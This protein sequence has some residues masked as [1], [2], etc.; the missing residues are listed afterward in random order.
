MKLIQFR[1]H[2]LQR[3]HKFRKIFRIEHDRRL[4]SSTGLLGNLEELAVAALL[5][6]DIERALASVNRDG[7]NLVGKATACSTRGA[8]GAGGC[9]CGLIIAESAAGTGK[10]RHGIEH[11]R[12]GRE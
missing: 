6:I 1:L 10:L 9:R 3:F 2:L 11:K 12:K 8:R 4:L 7:V 5:Q